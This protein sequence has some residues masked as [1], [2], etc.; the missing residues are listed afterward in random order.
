MTRNGGMVRVQIQPA[1]LCLPGALQQAATGA[2]SYDDGIRNGQLDLIGPVHAPI[3]RLGIRQSD[4]RVVRNGLTFD[5][6][7]GRFSDSVK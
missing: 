7:S 1:N 4:G 2:K 3:V 5:I 6:N